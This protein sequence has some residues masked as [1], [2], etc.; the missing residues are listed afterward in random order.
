[1][2]IAAVRIVVP[3]NARATRIAG[4]P[5]L[6][7]SGVSIGGAE[8]SGAEARVPWWD[9]EVCGYPLASRY[10]GQ[11]RGGDARKNDK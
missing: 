5:L 1:M 6:L 4:G 9:L 2:C 7:V 11:G 10:G 3:A 8:R